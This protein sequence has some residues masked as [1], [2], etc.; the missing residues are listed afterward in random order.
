MI[1]NHQLIFRRT[2]EQERILVAVNASENAY[3]ASHG[4]LNG[5]ALDLLSGAHLSLNGQIE[6]SPYSVLYLK[7]ES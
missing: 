2:A 6:L 5:D 4:D 7:M 3:T 1:T